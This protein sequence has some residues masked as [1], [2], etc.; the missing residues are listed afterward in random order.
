[1][2]SRSFDLLAAESL[3]V[4]N[5]RVVVLFTEVDDDHPISSMIDELFDGGRQP[6]PVGPRQ[7]AEEHAILERRAMG[8][9]NSMHRS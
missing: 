9:S 7:N 4:G 2:T 8:A 5:P 3:E 6:H 1:M